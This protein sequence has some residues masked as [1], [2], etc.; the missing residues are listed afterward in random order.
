[1]GINVYAVSNYIDKLKAKRKQTTVRS[2][3]DRLAREV[4]KAY[5]H[6]IDGADKRVICRDLENVRPEDEKKL[7]AKGA[8]RNDDGSWSVPESMNPMDFYDFLPFAP[9]DLINERSR[10]RRTRD[11]EPWEKYVLPEDRTTSTESTATPFIYGAFPVLAAMMLV[12]MAIP[13]FRWLAPLLLIPLA[14]NTLALRELSDGYEW[15]KA[16]LIGFAMPMFFSMGL[17][18]A[19]AASGTGTVTTLFKNAFAD[20]NGKTDTFTMIGAGMLVAVIV[21]GVLIVWNFIS[22]SGS[23]FIGGMRRATTKAAKFAAGAGILA[24]LYFILP[25][26]LKPAVPFI[27]ACALP[28]K[29]A[30][31]LF[32]ARAWDINQF[33]SKYNGANE[34]VKIGLDNED[35]N[36]QYKFAHRDKT[37]KIAIARALGVLAR[38]GFGS[39]PDAFKIMVVSLTDLMSNMIIFGDTGSGKTTGVFR[40]MIVQI[41]LLSLQSVKAFK[42]GMLIM[43]GKG[44]L[45]GEVSG[46]VDYNITSGMP[47]GLIEGLD[48]VALARGTNMMG[49]KS[50]DDGKDGAGKYWDDNADIHVGS[51]AKI[52]VACCDHSMKLHNM[53]A[54]ELTTAIQQI[55]YYQTKLEMMVA[56][57]NSNPQI[58]VDNKELINLRKRKT[59]LMNEITEGPSW[60]ASWKMWANIIDR[61]NNVIEVQG[62][63]NYFGEDMMDVFKFLGMEVNGVA[64]N[65]KYVYEPVTNPNSDV[66]LA[67]TYLQNSWRTLPSETRSGYMGHIVTRLQPLLNSTLLVD[68]HGTPWSALTTGVDVTEVL[69]GKHIGFD[70]HESVYGVDVA[71]GVQQL[72][73]RRVYTEGKRRA[74]YEAKGGWKKLFPDQTP[75]LIF[76]DEAH[77]FITDELDDLTSEMRSLE[78]AFVMGTQS[79]DKLYKRFSNDKSV[80]GFLSNFATVWITKSSAATYQ[81][82]CNR[83]GKARLLSFNQTTS[84]YDYTQSTQTYQNSVLHMD[85]HPNAAAFDTFKKYGMAEMGSHAVGH[86]RYWNINK[87]GS[88]GSKH[89][90]MDDRQQ[91][92]ASIVSAGSGQMADQD[93]VSTVEL[94][95]YLKNGKGSRAIL[96]ANRGNGMRVDFV[97]TACVTPQ[98]VPRILKTGQLN[99]FKG[100]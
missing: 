37:P 43:C 86:K 15:L 74:T 63:E 28:L 53:R 87:S 93:I 67:I 44:S 36:K 10:S 40:G 55:N 39:A 66:S 33:N 6:L 42:I 88:D 70:L 13:G 38:K 30:N 5:F 21:F 48:A 89:Y 64:P 99:L 81:W 79:V 100:D 47:V 34:Q 68:E 71:V 23:D 84:A 22:D 56:E 80:E 2:Q 32:N 46:A 61:S 12:M 51:M 94:N 57:D 4:R 16:T 54:T 49:K 41:R 31:N 60:E 62:G 76:Q 19:N 18:G 78:V 14:I 25:N 75:C 29:Y 1:M 77:K 91:I 95:D 90:D 97:K 3:E 8:I 98:D 92:H 27:A 85:D 11:N 82:F 20:Q 24:A 50:A 58:D 52:M 69:R 9:E 7:I 17:V 45:A 96:M 26:F 65:P 83:L 59:V 72:L 35:R 73:S